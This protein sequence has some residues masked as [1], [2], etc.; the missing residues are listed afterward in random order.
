M[1]AM[2][3]S[4]SVFP[5]SK[6]IPSEAVIVSHQLM[7]RAGLIRRLA[8]GLYT[9]LPFGLRVLRKVEAV[10]REEMNRVGGQEFLFPLLIPREFWERSGRWDVFQKEL[11]RLQDRHENFYALAP[12]HEE[13]FTDFFGREISSY[14]DMPLILYHIGTKF[15]DEIRPRYGVM[16]GREFIMKDAYSFH[17]ESTCL[18]ST[19]GKMSE[20][21]TC[22]FKR[23]ALDFVQVRAHSGAMGGEASEEFMVKSEVGEEVIIHCPTC[24]YVANVET[25]RETIPGDEQQK[26]QP[27]EKIPTPGMGKIDE[28]AKGLHLPS[29]RF[30]KCVIYEREKGKDSSSPYF[31]ALI[32]G[33]YEINETKLANHFAGTE[34]RVADKATLEKTLS[35]PVGFIGPLGRDKD[36]EILVD[37]TL[38]P[39]VNGVTGANERD[40]HYTGVSVPRD[41]APDHYGDFYQAKAGGKCPTCGA[42]LET[43][44]GIEVGHIFKLGK[45]YTEAFN[46]SVLDREGKAQAPVM[47]CYGIGL[48]RTLASIIEQHHDDRGIVWPASVAP[49]AV[50]ILT[51]DVSDLAS[52]RLSEGLYL[53]LKKDGVEVLWDDRPSRAGFKFNDADLLGIPLQIVVGPRGLKQGQVELRHRSSGEKTAIPMGAIKGRVSAWLH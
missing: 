42:S 13:A 9:Y 49:F 31:M 10:I 14:R 53:D 39:T 33:D 1:V 40:Y 21:Y 7:I 41:I 23:L 47:G 48:D 17:L 5:T 29:S 50:I 43:F 28:V 52:M 3:L 44:K 4:Q 34:I 46:V 26:E 22:I 32:R 12:T 38:R 15:R 6:E 16:R 18:D 19:Y 11:F 45:K 27:L 35:L 2:K 20:A 37:E 51:L 24:G 25:A 8:S 36:M 30:I